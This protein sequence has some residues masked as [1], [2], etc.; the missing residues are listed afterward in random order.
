MPRKIGEVFGIDGKKYRVVKSGKNPYNDGCKVCA[1]DNLDDCDF[2]LR[3]RGHCD[4][5]PQRREDANVHFEEV[6]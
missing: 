6:K 5:G 1:F 2:I 3:Y 4:L